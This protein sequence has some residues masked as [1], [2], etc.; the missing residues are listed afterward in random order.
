[1]KKILALTT[2]LSA[3]GLGTAQAEVVVMSWGGAY[4]MAQ[5]LSLI[6]I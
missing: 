2:A 3:A 5:T 1:M 6:H 4:G